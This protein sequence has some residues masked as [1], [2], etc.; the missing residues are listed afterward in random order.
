MGFQSNTYSQK[1]K[2]NSIRFMF[3]VSLSGHLLWV[4]PKTGMM[5]T[6][7]H[8]DCNTFDYMVAHNLLNVNNILPPSM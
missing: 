8:N 1:N 3:W 5:S 7:K 2:F 4:L 6:G